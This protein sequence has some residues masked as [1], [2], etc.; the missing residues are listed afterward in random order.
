MKKEADLIIYNAEIYTVDS[1]FSKA[2]AMAV[3]NGKIIYIGTNGE[4][5]DNYKPAETIDAANRPVYPGFIDAHCHFLHYGLGLQKVDLVGT[6]SFEEVLER[7]IEFSK[8]TTGWI[9]GRG[10]D[11]NDWEI[12][13]YP[14]NSSLDSLFPDRP[15]I[16]KRIDGHAGLANTKALKISGITT[17]TNVEGGVIE[18]K[19]DRLTGILNDNALELIRKAVPLPAE[20]QIINGLL[21]AQENCFGVGLTTVDDAGLKRSEIEIIDRLQKNGMLK[22]RIYAML[23]PDEENEYYLKTGRYKTDRLNVRS[24]KIYADGSL[25]SRGAALIEPYNDDSSNYGHIL[26]PVQ[27]FNEWAKR[28]YE[29]G[30]QLNIHCIGDSANRLILDTYKEILKGGNDKRWRIEHAQVVHPEDLAK[31]AE[32]NIIPSVQPTHATSDMYWAESRDRKSVV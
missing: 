29:A 5:I 19:N 24:F 27:Y 21:E 18:I 17:K 22:M 28:C 14:D 32:Y 7:T 1:T 8:N 13:E 30:F 11:Q 31:F 12:K 23:D 20:E 16:L 6:R 4:I 9:V 2:R 10:W 25:G 15:V 3:R 26:K